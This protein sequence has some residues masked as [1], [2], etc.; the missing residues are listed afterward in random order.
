MEEKK[1]K[2]NHRRN[3]QVV[4]EGRRTVSSPENA[5]ITVKPQVSCV[6]RSRKT[7]KNSS[8]V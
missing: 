3:L 4:G 5:K 2:T 8:Q 7:F 1:K 6:C